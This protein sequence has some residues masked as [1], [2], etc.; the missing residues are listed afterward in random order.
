LVFIIVQI[1][2]AFEQYHA[3]SFSFNIL[4]FSAEALVERNSMEESESVRPVGTD[5]LFKHRCRRL[6]ASIIEN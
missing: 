6:M 4:F 2:T 5:Y 3:G 1:D